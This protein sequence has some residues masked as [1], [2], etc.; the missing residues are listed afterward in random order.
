MEILILCIKIFFA[1]VI[2]VSLGTFRSTLTIKGKRIYSAS[3]GFFEALIWFL[4]VKEALAT[5]INNIW[6]AIAYASGFAIG[7]YIGGLISSLFISGTLT[8][9]VFTVVGM[10]MAKMLRENGFAVSII[11]IEDQNIE[12]DR[13]MLYIGVDNKQVDKLEKLIKKFDDSAFVV[14]NESKYVLN[15]YF[16]DQLKK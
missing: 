12:E 4:I 2:D 11:D 1:R 7:T 3:I 9:Q 6:I 16:K 13:M 14:V 15:G 10:D 8:V 5:P